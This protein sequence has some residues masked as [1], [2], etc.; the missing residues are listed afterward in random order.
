[1][2]NLPYTCFCCGYVTSNK[3]NMVQHF[4]KRKTPC[5]KTVNN[6][7]LTEEIMQHIL[8]NRIYIPVATVLPAAPKKVVNNI[9]YNTINNFVCSLDP[10]EKINK[11]FDYNKNKLVNFEDNVSKIYVEKAHLLGNDDNYEYDPENT[12]KLTHNNFLEI[13]NEI[14]SICDGKFENL[15]I[16]YDHK[17]NHIK[18]YD[19]GSWT[20]YLLASGLHK[21]ILVIQE[22]YL[23]YYEIYVIR[24]YHNERGQ[25][26][27]ILRELIEKYYRFLSCFDVEPYCKGRSDGLLL[28]DEE[29]NKRDLSDKLY[30]IYNKT[31]ITR[32]ELNNIRKEILDI[33]KRNTT[34]NIEEI[35]KRI[36]ELINVNEEFKSD[37]LKRLACT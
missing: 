14:S 4:Y 17:M 36:M 12:T 25:N 18:L 21:I 16:I 2:K 32:G 31:S 19:D 1:M 29:D 20:E 6:V 28:K 34:R 8:K 22:F 7:E 11:Y 26:Q 33:I 37:V 5:P 23:D 3:S 24:K 10:V 27:A 9:T 35:N 15:N 30:D 13:I